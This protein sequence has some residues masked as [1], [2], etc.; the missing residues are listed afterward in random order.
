MSGKTAFAS[1]EAAVQWLRSQ[2][3]QTELVRA[4]YYDDPLWEASERYRQS[5]EWQAI[6][7][8]ML[9]RGGSAL[10]IGAGRGIAS[11]ALARDGF[12]VTALEP[13]PSNLVG[14]GAI[15]SLARDAGV[16]IEVVQEVSERLPFADGSFDVVFARAVLH[17]TKDLGVACKEFFRVVKPGGLFIAVREHVISRRE[18]LSDFLHAHPLH[19]LYGGENAFLLNEYTDALRQAGFVIRSVLRPLESPIN[20]F[21]HTEDSLREELVARLGRLPGSRRMLR[22]LLAPKPVFSSLLRLLSLVD[23]RPGRL[24][25]FFCDK[26]ATS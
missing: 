13:D 15:R 3:N 10:D 19:D 18:D 14:A 17:H 26:P 5:D 11:Y 2:P 9:G 21:P 22:S 24:Y 12:K 7:E 4:A 1:W 20:Y 25:S 8:R 16:P 23:S 6:R